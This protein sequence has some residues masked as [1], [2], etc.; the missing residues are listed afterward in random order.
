MFNYWEAKI[1]IILCW[2]LFIFILIATPFTETTANGFTIYDK[3]IHF[4]MFGVFAFLLGWG[5]RAQRRKKG[6]LV[7]VIIMIV[8][9]SYI[10]TTEY[11]QSFIPTRNPAFWDVV[12]GAVGGLVGIL[13][14]NAYLDE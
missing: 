9:I 14:A 2:A 5:L 12:A 7:D 6:I 11:I 4:L 10:L 13:F 3:N 8:V 1:Y